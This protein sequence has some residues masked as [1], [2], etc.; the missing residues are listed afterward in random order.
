MSVSSKIRMLAK[1]SD[2]SLREIAHRSE[3]TPSCL[4][5]YFAGKAQRMDQA[6]DHRQNYHYGNGLVVF[7]ETQ[8]ATIACYQPGQAPV[9]TRLHPAKYREPVFSPG[10]Q[11]QRAEHRRQ[12]KGYEQR[13]DRHY[14]HGHRQ[15]PDEHADLAGHGRKRE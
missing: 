2:H 12:R 15:R 4:S 11:Q 6:A 9:K 10:L 14:D 8:H 5:R 1:T 7:G 13:N 3:I